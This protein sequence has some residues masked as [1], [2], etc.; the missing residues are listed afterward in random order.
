MLKKRVPL[1]G[2]GEAPGEVF[3]E[4]GQ[5]KKEPYRVRYGSFLEDSK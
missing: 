2:T 3:P 4:F 5:P 1:R